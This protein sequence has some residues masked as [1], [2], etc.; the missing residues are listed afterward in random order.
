M[1]ACYC[2]REPRQAPRSGPEEG[3]DPVLVL[4]SFLPSRR[5]AEPPPSVRP[6]LPSLPS[7]LFSPPAITPATS[8]SAAPPG[9][10]RPHHPATTTV[11]PR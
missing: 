11:Q 1:D 5:S 8:S 3:E 4:T 2:L 10:V 7:A 9:L 6:S